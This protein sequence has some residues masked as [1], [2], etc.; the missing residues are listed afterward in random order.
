MRG[1]ADCSDLR[2]VG[3]MEIVIDHRAR[4]KECRDLARLMSL[5]EHRDQ[6]IKMAEDLERLAQE[7]DEM[8]SIRS[9]SSL[10]D[11]TDTRKS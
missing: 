4:A 9:S 7:Q 1:D 5:D 11:A 10:P 8:L 6:P 2:G 3:G